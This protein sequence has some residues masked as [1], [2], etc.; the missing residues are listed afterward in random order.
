VVSGALDRLHSEED[1]AVKFVPS[2]KL[3]IYLHGKRTVDHPNW[4]RERIMK[5]EE[6]LAQNLEKAATTAPSN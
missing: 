2:S 1:P 4:Q 5:L 6:R 3:W